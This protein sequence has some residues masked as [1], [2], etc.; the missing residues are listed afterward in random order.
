MLIEI[1]RVLALAREFTD[2]KNSWGNFLMWWKCSIS[3]LECGIS[4]CVRLSKLIG[5]FTFHCV[6][7]TLIINVKH[8]LW[9]GF[10]WPTAI[11]WNPD[12]LA[13][14]LL[15]SLDR[16]DPGGSKRFPIFRRRV[17]PLQRASELTSVRDTGSLWWTC[18]NGT[19][20]INKC[21]SIVLYPFYFL[22]GLSICG[23]IWKQEG[24]GLYRCSPYRS[25]CR[26]IQWGREGRR[27][28]LKGKTEDICYTP[29]S[30]TTSKASFNCHNGGLAKRFNKLRGV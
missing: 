17:S 28:D 20:E 13:V 1:R 5:F 24:T 30:Y 6:Y 21:N 10:S 12:L 3:W 23:T 14:E 4:R 26:G 8:K 16:K 15:I 25:N 2:L 29:Y 9:V 27:L 19:S 11:C 18:R 22:L 7:C